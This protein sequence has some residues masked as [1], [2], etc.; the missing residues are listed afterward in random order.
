MPTVKEILP[1]VRANRYTFYNLDADTIHQ[2]RS[3]YA[4]LKKH[5][6]KELTL[7]SVGLANEQIEQNNES[8][9]LKK[10]RAMQYLS[11]GIKH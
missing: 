8:D 2:F 6:N 9:Y 11:R 4:Y 10:Y 1:I 7:F 5:Q 3:L